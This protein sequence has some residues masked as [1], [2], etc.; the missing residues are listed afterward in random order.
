VARH[1][2]AR[3]WRLK[4]CTSRWCAVRW[5]RAHTGGGASEARRWRHG[6]PTPQRPGAPPTPARLPCIFTEVEDDGARRQLVLTAVRCIGTP[7][8]DVDNGFLLSSLDDGGHLPRQRRLLLLN[9][10]HRLPPLCMANGGLFLAQRL[11]LGLSG[12]DLGCDIAQQ[13]ISQRGCF[14]YRTNRIGYLN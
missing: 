11:D 10:D 7:P 14:S 3:W 13:P 6:P 12:S 1:S 5:H 4:R 2:G 9:G 8:W